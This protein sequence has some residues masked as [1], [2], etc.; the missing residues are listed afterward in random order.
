MGEPQTPNFYDFGT[1]E[2]TLSSPNQLF[3]SLETP[4]HQNKN[5]KRTNDTFSKY[6]FANM[7]WKFP[8]SIIFEKAGTENDAVPFNQISK[9]LKVGK[10]LVEPAAKT[11]RRGFSAKQRSH[12]NEFINE[13][14]RGK[15]KGFPSPINY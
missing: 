6:T 11:L 4:G 8:K 7:F 1:F 12:W 10:K 13:Q 14:G 2:R 3:L 5:M 9:I 15:P